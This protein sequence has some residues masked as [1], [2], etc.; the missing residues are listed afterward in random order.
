ML[1]EHGGWEQR[2]LHAEDVNREGSTLHD[3]FV[4]RAW[5][6]T[7]IILVATQTGKQRSTL[8]QTTATYSNVVCCLLLAPVDST[9]GQM[10]STADKEKEVVM[11]RVRERQWIYLGPIAAAPVAH[12][13][14][15]LYRD[16]KTPRARTLLLGAGVFGSTFLTIGMRLYLMYHAGYPGGA[17]QGMEK[18]EKLVTLEEKRA[19]ENPSLS[20]VA[21]EAFRGFG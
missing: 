4:D 11:A 21:K 20:T 9:S 10:T 16:A 15:T 17:N 19:M 8:L 18:R 3:N 12:I 2:R 1:V 14:V 5:L 7:E 6:A 13:C